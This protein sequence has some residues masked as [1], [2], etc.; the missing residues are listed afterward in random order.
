MRI[1]DWSSDVCS[2]DL[3]TDQIELELLEPAVD[4]L[5]R[6]LNEV[7]RRDD[8]F[9]WHV[10]AAQLCL[11]DDRDLGLD[12]GVDELVGGYDNTVRI[13]RIAHQHAEG[14]LRHPHLTHIGL[15]GPACLEANE[16]TSVRP[17]AHDQSTQPHITTP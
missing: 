10:D 1:S 2:S 13:E 11:G 8:I 6:G 7:S 14:G 17:Q 9:E 3:D 15:G 16:D 4:D 5:D 12:A